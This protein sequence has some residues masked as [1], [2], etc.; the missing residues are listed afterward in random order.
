MKKADLITD[1]E[2]DTLYLYRHKNISSISIAKM[3]GR[4]T[5]LVT[6]EYRRGGGRMKYTPEEGRK[7][8]ETAVNKRAQ[9]LR[10]HGSSQHRKVKTLEEKID[11]IQM[12][13]EMGSLLI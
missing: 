11:A 5:N 6:S 2:R 12:Q 1:K 10:K 4:S 9:L 3:I 13:I 7:Y 8:H